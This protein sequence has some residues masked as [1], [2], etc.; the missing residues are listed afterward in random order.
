MGPATLVVYT[1][2]EDDQLQ[3]YLPVFQKA[4]PN[5]KLDIYREST[6]VVTAK[7]MAEKAN[8]QADVVWA[9]AATSLLAADQ[10]GMLQ[11][12]APRGLE[13]VN[14][15]FRDRRSP[16]TWVGTD[17]WESAFCVNTVE[18]KNKNLPMPTSWE[19]LAKPVYKGHIVMS[20]PASSGTGY[21][22]VASW[23][24]LYGEDKGWQYMDQLHENIAQYQHSGSKPCRV[25]GTGEFPIG[26]SFGYRGVTQKNQGQPLE[27]VW[28]KE[29]SGWDLEANA[30]VKKNTVKPE[31]RTF[32]DW[33][34]GDDI[35][36][37][38]AKSYPITT[39]KTSEPIPPGYLTDPL[40]QLAKNDLAWAA[41]ERERILKRW[42]DKYDGKSEPR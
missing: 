11:A 29:G 24:Q 19:D 37:E 39:V 22:S 42:A 8:P 9:L 28:P 33:A 18:I 32:L 7:F 10:E 17:V 12:Y 31:A 5:I 38:Y 15:Q 27:V 16:P 21:L 23:L 1:A 3:R 41:K 35:M 2:L 14:E 40:K 4:Y 26:V 34:I 6:G 30:L 13:R 25:A 20:N 36:K